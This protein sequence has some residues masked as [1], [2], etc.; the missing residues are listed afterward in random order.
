MSSVSCRV[1]VRVGFRAH[2]RQG[3]RGRVRVLLLVVGLLVASRG[4]LPLFEFEL[5]FEFELFEFELEF[6]LE[7]ECSNTGFTDGSNWSST[8][9]FLVTDQD[10]SRSMLA[11]TAVLGI[12]K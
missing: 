5:V 6:E 2:E 9:V 12:S 11:W 1:S 7:F 10:C 4:N 8:Q 3:T